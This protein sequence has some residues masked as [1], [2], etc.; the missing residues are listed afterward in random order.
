LTSETDGNLSINNVISFNLPA[1]GNKCIWQGVTPEF[2]MYQGMAAIDNVSINSLPSGKVYRQTNMGSSYSWTASSSAVAVKN[3]VC[4]KLMH[5]FGPEAGLANST[6]NS[7]Y[8][9]YQYEATG[10]ARLQND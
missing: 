8:Y 6:N 2:E 7:K 5:A 1:V 4:F 3:P 10:S 9:N